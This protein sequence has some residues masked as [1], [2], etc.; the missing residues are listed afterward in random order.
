MRPFSS[1]FKAFFPAL[2]Q[3]VIDVVVILDWGVGRG[4]G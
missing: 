1:H 4:G 2:N 3:K